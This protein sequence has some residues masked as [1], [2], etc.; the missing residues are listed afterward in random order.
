M[1]REINIQFATVKQG[2]GKLQSSIQGLET[3]FVKDID[4]KNKLDMVTTVHD[5]NRQY[6]ELFLQYVALLNK[7]IR[8]T[9]DAIA[10]MEKVDQKAAD[11]MGLIK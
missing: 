11:G 9:N 8:S 10:S 5:M 4:G 2:I 7:N 6:E 3:S 1:S